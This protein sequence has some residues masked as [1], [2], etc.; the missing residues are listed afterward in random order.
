MR[1]SITINNNQPYIRYIMINKCHTFLS[2]DLQNSGLTAFIGNSLS[3][4]YQYALGGKVKVINSESLKPIIT[5]RDDLDKGV[6]VSG[7][8][9]TAAAI[10]L[11][12]FSIPLTFCF[13]GL[14]YLL[15]KEDVTIINSEQ[16]LYYDLRQ[17]SPTPPNS[18][19][20][21]DSSL[22]EPHTFA[23]DNSASFIQQY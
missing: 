18:V 22:E 21:F 23:T 7:L 3:R 15:T 2:E 1:Y 11:I 9:K 13:K 12:W 19:Q 16:M 4:P 14:S 5:A 17:G 20:D 8:L 6:L 10:G